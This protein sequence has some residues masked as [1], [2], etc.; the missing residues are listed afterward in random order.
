MG[1]NH[2]MC[3]AHVCVNALNAYWN[4]LFIQVISS[5]VDFLEEGNSSRDVCPHQSA[6]LSLVVQPIQ[7]LRRPLLF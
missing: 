1:E 2:R 3:W 7:A 5:S 6:D 4:A